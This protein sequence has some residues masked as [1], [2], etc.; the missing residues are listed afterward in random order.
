M[1]SFFISLWNVLLLALAAVLFQVIRNYFLQEQI[2]AK[3][4]Y[5]E[6]VRVEHQIS[7]LKTWTGPRWLDIFSF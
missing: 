3:R 5:P 1:S 6:A 7:G 4:E 2:E